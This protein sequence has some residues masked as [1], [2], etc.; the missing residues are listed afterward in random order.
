MRR[1]RSELEAAS[2]LEFP[3]VAAT[4]TDP[5]NQTWEFGPDV[6]VVAT[7]PTIS[8]SGPGSGGG[9]AGVTTFTWPTSAPGFVLQTTTNLSAPWT[10]ATNAV[11]ISGS[12]YSVSIS[13]SR[14]ESFYRL[15]L[16]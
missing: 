15:I 10:D 12:N 14:P 5:N 8:V 7:A 11:T 2:R 16:Q 3:F 6:E 4:A 1:R 9:S 13:A